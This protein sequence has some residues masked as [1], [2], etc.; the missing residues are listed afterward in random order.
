MPPAPS[1]T[2]QSTAVANV[3]VSQLEHLLQLANWQVTPAS[4][5]ETTS[6][7]LTFF[8]VGGGGTRH[9]SHL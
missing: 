1:A 3:S 7:D 5:Y 8:L 6:G 2:R 4:F 9:Y